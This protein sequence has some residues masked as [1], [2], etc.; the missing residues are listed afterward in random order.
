MAVEFRQFTLQSLNWGNYLPRSDSLEVSPAY[1]T[2]TGVVCRM[3]CDC[4]KNAGGC[5]EQRDLRAIPRQGCESSILPN[6]RVGRVGPS[7]SARDSFLKS[8]SFG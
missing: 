4:E 1:R 8:S 3:S 7:V 5:Q 2:V 6:D